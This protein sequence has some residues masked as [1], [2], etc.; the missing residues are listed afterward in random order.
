MTFN[1]IT[2]YDDTIAFS[3]VLDLTL[4]LR[5]KFVRSSVFTLISI[6]FQF[7]S[8]AHLPWRAFM[9]KAFNTFI[10]DLFAFIITM[11]TAHR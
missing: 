9:Y 11:P 5:D 1:K 2:M 10:D 6:L 4:L 8:V 7:Q 3:A